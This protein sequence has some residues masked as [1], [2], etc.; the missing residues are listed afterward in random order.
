MKL[1]LSVVAQAGD[2]IDNITIKQDPDPANII[3]ECCRLLNSN[4]LNHSYSSQ[5]CWMQ[6]KAKQYKARE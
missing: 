4:R 6:S 5:Y 1:M 3:L 2:E